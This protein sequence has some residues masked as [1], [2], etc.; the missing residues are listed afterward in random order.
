MYICQTCLFIVTH[1]TTPRL[2][3]EYTIP[4][5]IN[6]K[7]LKHT[8]KNFDLDRCKILCMKDKFT[9]IDAP[10]GAGKSFGIGKVL[11]DLNRVNSK[12]VNECKVCVITYR[13]GLAMYLAEEWAL[14]CYSDI[15]K[16]VCGVCGKNYYKLQICMKEKV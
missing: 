7:H 10:C 12:T 16:G 1:A 8:K 2:F 15:A 4:L 11:Y 13:K 14:A 3:I 5:H 9:I 6:V